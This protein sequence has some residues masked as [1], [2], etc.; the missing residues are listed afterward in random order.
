VDALGALPGVQVSL[1]ATAPFLL[2]RVPDGPGVR[3][4]LREAGVAV[5]R[6]DTFPGLTADHL[7]VAI[8][9]P[10]QATALVRALASAVRAP[11]YGSR[12]QGSGS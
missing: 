2:L 9:P 1:P 5:R 3:A 11:S 7:R 8:R 12:M 10:A 6:A 4:R